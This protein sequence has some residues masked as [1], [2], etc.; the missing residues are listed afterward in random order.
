MTINIMVH[1]KYSINSNFER[2]MFLN[3]HFF[4]SFKSTLF[5][6]HFLMSLHI[7]IILVVVDNFILSSLLFS[8]ERIRELFDHLVKG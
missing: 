6:E 8:L 4:F 3:I 1:F 2:Y 7:S 5:Q